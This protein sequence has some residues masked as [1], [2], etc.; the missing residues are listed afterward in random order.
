MAVGDPDG[1]GKNWQW[2]TWDGVKW[3]VNQYDKDMAFGNYWTG[4]FTTA[5]MTGWLGASVSIPSGLAIRYY[6]PEHKARWQELANANIFNAEHIKS[7]ITA[8]ISRIGKDNF[9]QE[10]KKWPEAPCNRNSKIDFEH[11]KFTGTA[12]SGTPSTG[13]IWDDSTPYSVGDKIWFK[14]FDGTWYLQFEA[15]K[16]GDNHPC[17]TGS[18]SVYPMSMGYRDSAWRYY[19]Y[20]EETISNQNTFINS[21]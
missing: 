1:F 3:Y 8:W 10:W 15:V 12:S 20:V 7:M 19:K 18:Y 2:T 6:T 9:V 17:L 13:T 14:A 11:W 16:A 21:L 5:P 4:M